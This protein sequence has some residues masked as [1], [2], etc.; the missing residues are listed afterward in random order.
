MKQR[1]PL[2]FMRRNLALDRTKQISPAHP[3]SPLPR[4]GVGRRVPTCTLSRRGLAPERHHS[5]QGSMARCTVA[6]NE[7]QSRSCVTLTTRHA[8]LPVDSHGNEASSFEHSGTEDLVLPAS[9]RQPPKEM[10]PAVG[11]MCG[12][13]SAQGQ[14]GAAHRSRMARP[15]KRLNE[16]R[17]IGRNARRLQLRSSTECSLRIPFDQQSGTA[18]D[19]LRINSKLTKRTTKSYYVENAGNL[20]TATQSLE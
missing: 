9:A 15:R 4:E 11:P 14:D 8:R 3:K 18:G 13:R 20:K 17:C 16:N 12:C 1:M 2:L 10:P 7:P 5:V 19:L 6:A